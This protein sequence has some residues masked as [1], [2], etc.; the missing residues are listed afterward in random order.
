MAQTISPWPPVLP[1]ATVSG[2]GESAARRPL[3]AGVINVTPDSFSDGGRFQ[4]PRDALARAERLIAEGADVL[5]IGGESTRPGASPVSEAEEIRRVVPLLAALSGRVSAPISIDTRRPAVARAAMGV[6]ARIWNDVSGLT[7][8]A[9]SLATAAKLGCDVVLT[10]MRGEPATMQV[11]PRYDDVVAEVIAWLAGRA[12]A[13]IGAG[14]ASD[15]ILLDPGIGF[16]KTLAHNL[17]LLAGLDRLVALGFPVVLGASRKGLIRGLDPSAVD[18]TDRLGGSLA[19]ALAGARAGCAMVR[20]HDVRET[21]QA[22]AVNRAI[23][24]TWAAT[25]PGGSRPVAEPEH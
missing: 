2:T 12:K 5:D 14:V 10:H 23:E 1:A 20:V 25:H 24:R 4:A 8:A 7:F 3:V 11:A 21:V 6:G 13:A 15:R 17:A 18:P 9:D 16:G 22:L 19:L